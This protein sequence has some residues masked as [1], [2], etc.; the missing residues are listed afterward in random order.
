MSQTSAN[1]FI[2]VIV[3]VSAPFAMGAFFLAW[4]PAAQY[5]NSDPK[6]DGYVPTRSIEKLVERTQYS[7]VTVFCRT[8]KKLMSLGTAWAI[9]LKNGQDKKYP[10]SLITNHH[11]I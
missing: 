10:A 4:S 8:G 2:A 7:T 5:A 9:D 11:V 3:I 1:K 6:H